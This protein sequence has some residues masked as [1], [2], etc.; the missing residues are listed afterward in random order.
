MAKLSS[1]RIHNSKEAWYIPHHVISHNNK[2]HIVF[3]CSFTFQGQC[4]N[5]YLLPG[6]ILGRT[7]LGVLLCFRQRSAAVSGKVKSMFHQVH[8]CHLVNRS[9]DSFGVI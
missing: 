7:L 3:D 9:S 6:P 1:E 2:D 4:L 8:L 5:K